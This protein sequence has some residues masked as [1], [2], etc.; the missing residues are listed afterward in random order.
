MYLYIAYVMLFVI[1]IIVLRQD[2]VVWGWGAELS[3]FKSDFNVI[4]T[5][6]ESFYNLLNEFNNIS[7]VKGLNNILFLSN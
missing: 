3:C 4:N 1:N 7:Q 6:F 2:H 5:F